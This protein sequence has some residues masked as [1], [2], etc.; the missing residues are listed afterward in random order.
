[1]NLLKRQNKFYFGTEG[2]LLYQSMTSHRQLYIQYKLKLSFFL[3]RAGEL[4]IF[5]IL[6][7]KRSYKHETKENKKKKPCQSKANINSSYQNSY[8]C[9]TTHAAKMLTKENMT[10]HS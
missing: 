5:R 9:T 6:E 3:E 1:M 10:M 7:K 8:Y 2:V 4:R